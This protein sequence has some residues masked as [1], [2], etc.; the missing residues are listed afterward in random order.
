MFIEKH[1]ERVENYIAKHFR[2]SPLVNFLF[3]F[4]AAA[5]ELIFY[6]FLADSSYS[7]M[8]I[9]KIASVLLFAD[10]LTK[11]YFA[12]WIFFTG[13]AKESEKWLKLVQCFMLFAAVMFFIG[14]CASLPMIF[15]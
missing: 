5:L 4:I 3:L 7:D 11:N 15:Y 13:K 6:W 9:V 1:A 2:R 14:F 8:L 10:A 12:I